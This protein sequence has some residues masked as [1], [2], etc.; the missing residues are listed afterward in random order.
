MRWDEARKGQAA[1]AAAHRCSDASGGGRCAPRARASGGLHAV[2]Q[3]RADIWYMKWM[4]YELKWEERRGE[5]CSTPL[6]C[7]F[8]SY[9]C[10][11]CE[12]TL[13]TRVPSWGSQQMRK[14]V[15]LGCDGTEWHGTGR[16]GMR[17]N[18]ACDT[19]RE[20]RKERKGKEWKLNET[21]RNATRAADVPLPLPL[22]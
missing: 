4:I 3:N 18:F 6:C 21:Q 10:S 11:P 16:D 2:E 22:V 13:I 9:D 7:R 1:A 12:A 15:P 8:G 14:R 17:A 5:E 19:T 20:I